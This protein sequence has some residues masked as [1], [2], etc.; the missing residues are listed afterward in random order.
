MKEGTKTPLLRE[1]GKRQAK[2]ERAHEQGLKWRMVEGGRERSHKT[3]CYNYLLSLI[4]FWPK[5]VHNI[6]RIPPV[7][8]LKSWSLYAWLTFGRFDVTD[9][10]ISERLVCIWSYFPHMDG[11]GPAYHICLPRIKIMDGVCCRGG[12]AVRARRLFSKWYAHTMLWAPRFLNLIRNYKP[13][14]INSF[15]EE[16][17]FGLFAY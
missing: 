13:G 16:F 5:I 2:G 8:N 11:P 3:F 4:W 6:A 10:R 12:N 9:R 1:G 17:F 7:M 15:W 14:K